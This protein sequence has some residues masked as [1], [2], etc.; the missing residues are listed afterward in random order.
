MEKGRKLPAQWKVL[1][2][3]WIL[4]AVWYTVK[5]N[6]PVDYKWGLPILFIW[7]LAAAGGLLCQK[8]KS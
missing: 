5:S 1:L 8:K 3:I 4:Y 7:Y 6:F 2:S